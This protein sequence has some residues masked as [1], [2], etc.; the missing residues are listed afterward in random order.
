VGG[1]EGEGVTR[2]SLRMSRTPQGH[3]AP[4][5]GYADG[6]KKSPAA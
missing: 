2:C 5:D 3:S 4:N 1:S 6:N